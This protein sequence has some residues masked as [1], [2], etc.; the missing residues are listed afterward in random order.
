MTPSVPVHFQ[1]IAYAAAVFTVI[2]P[3][4]ILLSWA[5]SLTSL[6]RFPSDFHTIKPNTALGI[7]LCGFALWVQI[8]EPVTFVRRRVAQFC[9]ALACILAAGTLLEYLFSVPLGLNP[10]HLSRMDVEADASLWHMAPPTA[11]ALLMLGISLFRMDQTPVGGQHLTQ[12]AAL[13]G[14]TVVSVALVGYLY[15][16][17]SLYQVGEFAS[18]SLSAAILLSAIGVGILCARPENGFMAIL[19]SEDLGGVMLRRLLP[20]AV[21][22]PILAGWIRITAQRS[23][24]YGFNFGVAVAVAAVIL[25]ILSVLW[26]LAGTLNR[27]DEQKK[28]LLRILQ[29]REARHRLALKAGRMGT[30]HQD[31]DSNSLIWSPELET[32]FG[33]APSSASRTF[34]EF[35]RLLH[36]EDRSRV[37]ETIG[38]AVRQRG[39]YDME[40]RIL[41]NPDREELWVAVTGQV[42]P[43]TSG[44]PRQITGVIFD[45]TERKRAERALQQSEAQLRT[46]T[47]ALPGLIGYVD[48]EERFRFVNAGY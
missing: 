13:I 40:C 26:V 36:P 44:Q 7:L 20:F 45:I 39:A 38:E 33:L 11:F 21:G 42:L 17:R 43:D 46:I 47:D 15:D 6:P 2:L 25:I 19:A 3:I 12:Y 18:I 10:I 41:R 29:Q 34:E 31:L 14:G 23:G 1:R 5:E 9:A 8:P 48:R 32:I 22:L 35:E 24:H 37:I 16:V 4:G 28:H 27:T 30:F